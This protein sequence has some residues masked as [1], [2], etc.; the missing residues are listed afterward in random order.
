MTKLPQFLL[1]ACEKDQD[2]HS[3]Y[4]PKSETWIVIQPK[5]NKTWCIQADVWR[6]IRFGLTEKEIS[7]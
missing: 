4:E 7:I 3:C 1:E 5:E 6:C 2:N